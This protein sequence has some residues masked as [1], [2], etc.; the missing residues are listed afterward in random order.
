[1]QHINHCG[2]SSNGVIINAAV[3]TAIN[4]VDTVHCSNWSITTAGTATMNAVV[5]GAE[6]NLLKEALL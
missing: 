4:L 1:M 3:A 6:V 2:W 5:S